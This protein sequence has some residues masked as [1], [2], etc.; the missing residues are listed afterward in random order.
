MYYVDSETDDDDDKTRSEIEIEN[1]IEWAKRLTPINVE[2]VER[3]GD[4]YKTL[5]TEEKEQTETT[6]SN[7]KNKITQTKQM[8]RTIITVFGGEIN[9]KD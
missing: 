5:I 6:K 7:D 4:K 1:L 2:A 8:R 9:Y 3:I